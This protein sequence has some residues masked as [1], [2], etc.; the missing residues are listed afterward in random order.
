MPKYV[1]KKEFLESCD[2]HGRAVFSK[3]I[4]M[5]E[6]RAMSI[7]WGTKGFTLGV[8]TDKGR[9]SICECYPPD[10]G[11]QSLYTILRHKVV[12]IKKKMDAPVEFI[13]RLCESAA[14]TGLFVSAGNELKCV[15]E[16][17]F[18]NDEAYRLVAWCEA[19]GLLIAWCELT[20]AP[21]G[22]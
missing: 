11:P 10:P 5:A 13:D 12:G 15:I 1:T 17:E 7:N 16:Q 9:V 18:T 21:E 19:M 8:V 20:K 22:K 14:A 6:R 3:I 4:D 2:E